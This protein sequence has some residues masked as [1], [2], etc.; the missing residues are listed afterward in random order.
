MNSSNDI[1]RRLISDGEITD[2][3]SPKGVLLNKA[4]HLF[5][6]QG[7]ERTTVRDIGRAVGI[8]PGSIFHH[9]RSKDEILRT[10]MRENIIVS[11]AR[12]REALGREETLEGQLRA[13][14]RCELFATNSEETGE[15]WTVLVQEWRSLSPEGQR[16]ILVL[17]EEYE[18]HWLETLEA[19]RA[20]GRI[21][22]DPFILRRLLAGALNWTSHWFRPDRQ[23]GLS[24]DELTEEVLR[25]V[26]VPSSAGDSRSGSPAA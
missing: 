20:Q 1:K 14:V 13:L 25:L 15:A 24:L 2:P 3:D 21:A 18:Q 19:A 16:E 17:R 10:V 4:A 12:L 9:F 22:L 23:P 11:L 7:Y 5:R 26:L 6:T 8:L